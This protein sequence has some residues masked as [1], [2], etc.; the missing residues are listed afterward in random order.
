MSLGGPRVFRSSRRPFFTSPLQPPGVARQPLAVGAASPSFLVTVDDGQK[1]HARTVPQLP[2][3]CCPKPTNR[4]AHRI[5]AG[6]HAVAVRKFNQATI[7]VSSRENAAQLAL[8]GL[9]GPIGRCTGSP[10]STSRPPSSR[11]ADYL[12]R[13]M[14][15]F[16]SARPI[17]SPLTRLGATPAGSSGSI[18]E[19]KFRDVI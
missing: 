18:T 8:A 1:R 6:H 7:H 14:G 12:D 19:A 2:S 15:D 13:M 11:V 16:P 10:A 3:V 17:E 9:V 5:A 4:F